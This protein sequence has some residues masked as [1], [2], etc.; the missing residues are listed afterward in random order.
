MQNSSLPD[1]DLISLSPKTSQ[2]LELVDVSMA[3]FNKLK[4]L[5]EDTQERIKR[6]FLPDRVTASLNIEGISATRRQ[7][8]AIMDALFISEMSSASIETKTELEIRNALLADEFIFDL[9]ISGEKMTPAAIRETNRIIQN[10]IVEFPGKFRDVNIEITQAKFTPPDHYEI[11]ELVNILCELF[12]AASAIHPILRSAWLHNRFTYIHPFI[13]GNGRTG[14]LLQDFSL[15]EAGLFPTG[16]P[17]SKRDDYYDALELAD[18]GE[19]DGFVGL[20]AERQ[21][22]VIAKASGI[23]KERKQREGWISA[24]AIRASA[25]KTGALNKQYL[26]WQHKMEIVQSQFF[27]AAEEISESIDDLRIGTNKFETIPFNEWKMI[28]EKGGIPRSWFFSIFFNFDNI[29]VYRSTFYFKRHT[30]RPNQNFSP[31][32][33]VVSLFLTGNAPNARA[34]FFDYEDTDI[35][36][37]ELF[38]D[39]ENRVEFYCEDD[40][41]C[42][43]AVEIH[44]PGETKLVQSFFENVLVNKLGI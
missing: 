15:I 22:D 7:T 34:E 25:K 38:F 39:A 18:N 30:A 43:R 10:D 24:L 13:D 16:V 12:N 1:P 2:M 27:D 14:R 40:P 26:V 17:S 21:L 3:E 28:L 29:E 35:S 36:F 19:W 4:P 5:D 6:S 41:R 23:A 31:R 20:I 9:A 11:S 37:R 8:L 32:S 44:D 33:D 42:S